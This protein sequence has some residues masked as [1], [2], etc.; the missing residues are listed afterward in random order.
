MSIN[1]FRADTTMQCTG[2]LVLYYFFVHEK[3]T[4]KS[5][6]HSKIAELFSFALTAYICP[7]I[8]KK[9]K[10][11]LRFFLPLWMYDFEVSLRYNTH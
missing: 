4:S 9:Y 10:N 7:K 1:I 3:K 8:K 5:E 11:H 2:T 6:Y